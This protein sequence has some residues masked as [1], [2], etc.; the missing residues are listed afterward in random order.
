ME[1][2]FFVVDADVDG[3]YNARAVNEAIFT[4]ADTLDQLKLNIAEAME[5]HFGDKIL[6]C[7]DL[8][9]VFAK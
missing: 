3:G 5:C 8:K 2:L 4:Q 7:F 6:P 1:N 9:F